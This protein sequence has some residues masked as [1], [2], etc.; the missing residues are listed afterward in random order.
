MNGAYQFLKKNGV[1]ISFS[2]GAVLALLSIFVIVGGFPADASKEALYASS[3]FNTALN[4]TFALIF[5]CTLMAL[6]G[7]VY[8]MVLNPRGAI[9]FGII[10]A[11]L[12]V[13]YLISS[14][15]GST[16]TA[17]QLIV[18]QG[19]HNKHL[20]AEDVAFV[21]GLLTFTVIMMFLALA[22]WLFSI[23][24]GIIKQR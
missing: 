8:G 1:T 15:M 7:A 18:F 6:A 20:L 14:A 9:R 13:L 22:A 21:D 23:V 16:P 2:L 19:N 5:I 4:I 17:E 12:L 24:W 11:I 10:A 3:V